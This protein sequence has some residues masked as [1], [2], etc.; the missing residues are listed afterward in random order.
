MYG[1]G[2][3]ISEDDSIEES[4]DGRYGLDPEYAG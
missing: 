1:D 3:P 2:G 4:D